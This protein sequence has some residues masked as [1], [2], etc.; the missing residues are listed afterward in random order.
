[1]VFCIC[2]IIFWRTLADLKMQRRFTVYPQKPVSASYNGE[3]CIPKVERKPAVEY[4]IELLEHPSLSQSFRLQS[5]LNDALGIRVDAFVRLIVGAILDV[6][7]HMSAKRRESH[8]T[9]D[10]ASNSVQL[11]DTAF[12]DPILYDVNAQ[13]DLKCEAFAAFTLVDA[14]GDGYISWEDFIEFVIEKQA[15]ECGTLTTDPSKNKRYVLLDRVPYATTQIFPSVCPPP[16]MATTPRVIGPPAVEARIIRNP[17]GDFRSRVEARR[18]ANKNES[19]KLPVSS[20]ESLLIQNKISPINF[21]PYLNPIPTPELKVLKAVPKLGRYVGITNHHNI[22]CYNSQLAPVAATSSGA[23]SL[24]PQAVPC[25][26]DM[27]SQGCIVSGH[28]MR[29]LKVWGS[30]IGSMHPLRLPL[31]FEYSCEDLITSLHAWPS[32]GAGSMDGIVL[33]G[34]SKGG[35][36]IWNLNQNN[37]NDFKRG[38][39][40]DALRL[41]HT[42]YYCPGD[43]HSN[44]VSA[45]H[46]DPQLNPS[47]FISGDMGGNLCV[48][49]IERQI[50]LRSYC[51]PS[52]VLGMTNTWTTE[53]LTSLVTVG[54]HPD[55]FLW[56]VRTKQTVPIR[57][58]DPIHPHKGRVP[59]VVANGI[60]GSPVVM[61]CDVQSRFKVWDSRMLRCVQTIDINPLQLSERL[62]ERDT[63]TSIT[64]WFTSADRVALTTSGSLLFVDAEANVSPKDCFSTPPIGACF[65]KGSS[66]IFTCHNEWVVTWEGDEGIIVGAHEPRLGELLDA[67]KRECQK[68]KQ[69]RLSEL[70]ERLSCLIAT[71]KKHQYIVGT[72]S[73]RVAKIKAVTGE[74]ITDFGKVH[75]SE[76]KALAVGYLS[77]HME[78]VL[79]LGTDGVLKCLTKNLAINDTFALEGK[80]GIESFCYVK[81]ESGTVALGTDDGYVLIV[82]LFSQDGRSTTKVETAVGGGSEGVSVKAVS[83][84]EPLGI[85]AAA[86]T[87]GCIA[88]VS[89]ERG[90]LLHRVLV[91]KSG[92]PLS[93][94]QPAIRVEASFIRFGLVIIDDNGDVFIAFVARTILDPRNEAGKSFE[95]TQTITGLHSQ[96]ISGLSVRDDGYCFVTTC[97][98]GTAKVTQTDDGLEC[99]MLCQGRRLSQ[100]GAPQAQK[101]HSPLSGPVCT[102]KDVAIPFYKCEKVHTSYFRMITRSYNILRWVHRFVNILRERIRCRRVKPIQVH[103]PLRTVGDVIFGFMHSE[104]LDQPSLGQAKVL[105]KGCRTASRGRSNRLTPASSIFNDPQKK[106][107]EMAVLSML[108]PSASVPLCPYPPAKKVSSANSHTK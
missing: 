93:L 58:A 52:G 57:L 51:Q 34:E 66:R 61:T 10:V 39:D 101:F 14:D 12:D 80:R 97:L 49:D 37:L 87:D 4:F 74:V 33:T 5:A 54:F 64:P 41:L 106:I 36:K 22:I 90:N 94:M 98:D 108:R 42:D 20:T 95:I 2:I 76:V 18:K 99:G 104:E 79:S 86:L 1:M 103:S 19:P 60:Q 28:T 25:F 7:E 65:E 96:P 43:R 35:I 46:T 44:A 63:I 50:L 75:S 77:Y 8:F 11:T 53:S 3:P 73:G 16:G 45:F 105:C 102:K 89:A 69:R 55:P 70:K 68:A 72:T 83:Y 100:P 31:Q 85:V 38:E 32:T 59:Y 30:P 67:T 6:A 29:L 81:H 107:N 40:I 23:N 71:P 84:I 88:I 91:Q 9:L 13:Y 62:G 15:A 17:T 82:S 48:N 47:H 26:V 56:D 78:L 27:T 24:F 21:G 92:V